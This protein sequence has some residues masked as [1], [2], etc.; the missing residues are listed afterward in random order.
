M[1]TLQRPIF[2]GQQTSCETAILAEE[3]LVNLVKTGQVFNA[4]AS[5]LRPRMDDKDEQRH[6]RRQCSCVVSIISLSGPR[7]PDRRAPPPPACRRT[8]R[9]MVRMFR[10]FRRWRPS[11][12][13]LLY[14]RPVRCLFGSGP[15]AC[16]DVA[17]RLYTCKRLTC[18][19]WLHQPVSWRVIRDPPPLFSW[20]SRRA[21]LRQPL[22]LK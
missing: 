11:G 6:Q 12:E 21:G 2:D 10:N 1:V 13:C 22:F 16:H 5:A 19:E 20:I 3:T 9:A 7:L 17:V 4:A 15:P 8:S 14:L 18:V